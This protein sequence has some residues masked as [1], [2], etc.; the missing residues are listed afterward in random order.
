MKIIAWRLLQFIKKINFAIEFY[1][2]GVQ[3][4]P[5]ACAVVNSNADFCFSI[6]EPS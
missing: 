4:V 1:C 6:N 2:R 5:E 3:P